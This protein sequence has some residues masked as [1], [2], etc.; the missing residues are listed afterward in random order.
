MG[1]KVCHNR[2]FVLFSIFVVAISQLLA[3]SVLYNSKPAS[4]STNSP[5]YAPTNAGIVPFCKL[6]RSHGPHRPMMVDTQ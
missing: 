1:S 4:A 6:Y 2:W 3:F 5:P